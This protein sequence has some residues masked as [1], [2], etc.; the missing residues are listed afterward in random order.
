MYNRDEIGKRI[1]AARLEKHLSQIKFAELINVSTPYLS[2]IENGKTN[3]S[4]E[5]FVRIVEA[6]QV[7]AD[8]LIMADTPQSIECSSAELNHLLSD[9]SVNESKKW[10]KIS[11]VFYG[12]KNRTDGFSPNHQSLLLG[13]ICYIVRIYYFENIASFF[14]RR[15]TQYWFIL[16]PSLCECSAKDLCR[17]L[18]ILNLNCPE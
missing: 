8:W 10:R 1:K 9:C 3:L 6:L 15:Y 18:G 12:P 7:S 11:K 13:I 17:L 14:E 2:D 4:L 16:I 5:I